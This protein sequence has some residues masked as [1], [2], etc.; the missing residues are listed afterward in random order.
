MFQHIWVR[1]RA[2]VSWRSPFI[3]PA[4]ITHALQ[5]RQ[6]VYHMDQQWSEGLDDDG[7]RHGC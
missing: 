5:I 3:S 7:R 2:R 4:V 6:L 1:I